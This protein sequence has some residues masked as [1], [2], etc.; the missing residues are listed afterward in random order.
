MH[1]RAR[2]NPIKHCQ[3]RKSVDFPFVVRHQPNSK[4]G[5][6]KSVESV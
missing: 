3:A 2:T 5:I 6:E 1:A 4:R